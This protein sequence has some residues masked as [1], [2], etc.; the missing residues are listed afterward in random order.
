MITSAAPQRSHNERLKEASPTLAGTIAAT[1]ADP[2]LD[3][4][5]D[6]DN[7]FLKFHGIYQQDDRDRRK[8]GKFYSLMIRG[9]IPGGIL[10]P[11]SYLVYDDL[12]TRHGNNTL[13]ITSRQ[14]FQFH[15][16]VKS[17]LGP[18]MKS[19]HE[20]LLTTIAA[21]GDVAR[22]VMAPPT[23]VTNS[24]GAQLLADAQRVSDALVPKTPAYHSIWVEGVQLDLEAPENKHFADPLYGQAY[25]PRKFKVAFALPPLN[26]VDLFTNCLGFI[27]IA[28]DAGQL[29]GYNLTAGGG[30]GRSHGNGQTFPRLADVIGFL[31]P[32]WVI[33]TAKAALTVHRDF[34]DRSDRKHA[35]LKYLLAEKGGAWFRAELEQRLGF[36]LE[37]P[38]PFKFERQGD[39]FGWH[40]QQDGRLFLGLF[41]EAGRI[42]DQDG[43]RLKTALRQVVEKFQ[44]EVRLTPSQNLLLANLG[45]EHQAEITALLA[46]HGVA[47]AQQATVVRRA[48]M[49]CVALPTCGLALAEAE[50]FLPGLLE[51]ISGLLAEVGL[52]DE[53]I[54]IR[55]TGCPNGC[56]RPYTAEIALVGKAPGRYQ[57]YLGG[58][59]SSTRLNRLWQDVVKDAEIL[60][61]LRPVLTRFVIERIGRERFGDWCARVLWTET[62]AVK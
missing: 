20:A 46:E 28:G 18:L 37:E 45:P 14:S 17:H 34:G 21:C 49:A 41:V 5:S 52:K 15:G 61:T 22:N 38:K 51:R 25:L 54:I 48:S 29:L 11:A 7:Q 10:A 55:M 56:V 16:V 2:A 12:A 24:L 62:P 58:N 32:G 9:R 26:D 53:E 60:D 50:R 31:T 59:E 4:F 39:L 42:K 27:A 40:R 35:R 47:V 8:T 1:L 3:R 36:K 43:Y 19:L 23:P 6:D 33:E 13:R 44:P 57:L 30:M